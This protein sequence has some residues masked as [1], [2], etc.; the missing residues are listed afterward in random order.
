MS[1]PSDDENVRVKDYFGT[2]LESVKRAS[3]EY[4]DQSPPGGAATDSGSNSS[5]TVGGIDV[6]TILAP[7]GRPMSLPD[8]MAELN[9]GAMHVQGVLT[10]LVDSGLI[11][12]T[13]DP[14]SEMVSLT[15]DGA[16]FT[17]AAS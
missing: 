1:K 17:S 14:G 3:P 10:P 7:L 9:I 6:L 2:F 15:Q 13:G 16:R 4:P 11:E 8:L 12:V 5:S